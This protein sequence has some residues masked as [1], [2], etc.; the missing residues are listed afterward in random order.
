MPWFYSMK[1]LNWLREESAE[2][3]LSGKKKSWFEMFS[4]KIVKLSSS[5]TSLTYFNCS[6][7]PSLYMWRKD[8]EVENCYC[9]GV[10]IIKNKTIGREKWVLKVTEKV[11]SLNIQ[12]LHS[13]IFFCLFCIC[14][15]QFSTELSVTELIFAACFL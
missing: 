7:D 14:I 10:R 3:E 11:L 4:Y 9:H 2:I 1:F 12:I 6:M 15:S 5:K 13:L 8:E